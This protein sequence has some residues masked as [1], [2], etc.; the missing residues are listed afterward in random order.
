MKKKY[1]QLISAFDKVFPVIKR[2][3]LKPETTSLLAGILAVFLHPHSPEFY[4]KYALKMFIRIFPIFEVS[5]LPALKPVLQTIVPWARFSNDQEEKKMFYVDVYQTL[6]PLLENTDF[7]LK[8]VY[9]DTDSIMV[10]PNLIK[11][12][13]K[14]P[15]KGLELRTKSIKLGQYGSKIICKLLPKPEN[16]EYEKILSP[17]LILSKKRYVGNLYENDPNKFYQKNMQKELERL[18]V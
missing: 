17:F 5:D 2:Q 18:L 14:E 6:T 7:N 15:I 16:L 11:C 10:C 12:D 1:Q 9:G 3:N 8:V 13:T 4:R